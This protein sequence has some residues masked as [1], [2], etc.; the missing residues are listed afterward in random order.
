[1]FPRRPKLDGPFSDEIYITINRE[2]EAFNKVGREKGVPVIAGCPKAV[3]LWD[4]SNCKDYVWLDLAHFNNHEY[5]NPI[6]KLKKNGCLLEKEDILSLVRNSAIFNFESFMDF[7]RAA[8]E[9]QPYRMYGSPYK[10]VY[11]LIK[12]H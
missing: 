5:I 4:L 2:L 11:F 10:P 9:T 8:K 1:M 3:N 7:F 6:S 12:T